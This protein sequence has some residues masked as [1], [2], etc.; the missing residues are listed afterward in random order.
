MIKLNKVIKII[1][2]QNKKSYLRKITNNP[3]VFEDH[4]GNSIKKEDIINKE[5]GINLGSYIIVKPSIDDFVLYYWKRKTQIV[6]PKDASYIITKLGLNYESKIL[7][8]ATGSGVMTLFLAKTV[9][10]NGKIVSVEKNY[11]FLKNAIKN[12]EDFDQTFETNYIGIINFFISNNINFLKGGFD[13]IFLDIPNPIEVIKQAHKLLRASGFL[14]CVLPTTNQVCEF[15]KTISNNYIDIDVEEIMLRK[16][17]PNYERLRPNDIM[18]A[19]TTY[20]ISAK[21]YLD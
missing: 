2:L 7:E 9:F 13:A 6:Y 15:L 4:L 10:P 17:K 20:I 3:K 12:L 18:T 1:N 5:Y 14:V 11:D 8:I 19:H 16:Y 21:K